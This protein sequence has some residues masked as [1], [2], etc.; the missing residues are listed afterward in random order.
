VVA[1]SVEPRAAAERARD[2]LDSGAARRVLE[3][4]RRTALALRPRPGAE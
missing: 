2:A 4:W 1:D 3:T